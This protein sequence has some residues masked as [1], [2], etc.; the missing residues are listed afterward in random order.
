MTNTAY[1]QITDNSRTTHLLKP[2]LWP[3]MYPW[4]TH[5]NTNTTIW[6]Y[7]L[8]YALTVI[9]NILSIVMLFSPLTICNKQCKTPVRQSRNQQHESNNYSTNLI[10]ISI[11][12]FFAGIFV[13][14]CAQI[15]HQR[16]HTWLAS[17]YCFL[18]L[19]WNSGEYRHKFRF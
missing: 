13:L 18:S 11:V 19:F 14:H 8:T 3:Q 1:K 2:R 9:C 4:G 16:F 6:W 15:A 10:I 5:K 7:K 17:A 12:L